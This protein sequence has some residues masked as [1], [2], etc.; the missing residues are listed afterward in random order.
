MKIHVLLPVGTVTPREHEAIVA[1]LTA[2]Y[3][4]HLGALGVDRIARGLSRQEEKMLMDETKRFG[5][6]SFS[7][8]KVSFES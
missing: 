6:A 2:Y 1:S 3:F 5:E 8:S 7:G 4:A